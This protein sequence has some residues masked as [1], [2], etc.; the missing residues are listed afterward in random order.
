M[1][2]IDNPENYKAT[3]DLLVE[4][5]DERALW[6]VTIVAFGESKQDALEKL[7]DMAF[8]QHLPMYASE[9]MEEKWRVVSI[10]LDS[11]KTERVQ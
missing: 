8:S 4:I 5:A 7:G 6:D 1:T 9:L 10:Q 2:L 11:L 3:V